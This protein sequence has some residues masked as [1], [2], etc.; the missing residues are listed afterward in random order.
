MDAVPGVLKK[1]TND[2][3]GDSGVVGM[4]VYYMAVGTG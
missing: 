3:F 4:N 2:G 1:T